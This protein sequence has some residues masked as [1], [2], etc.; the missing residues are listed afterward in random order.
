MY[1]PQTF[2]SVCK[3]R[4]KVI[5]GLNGMGMDMEEETLYTLCYVDN[6]VIATLDKKELDKRM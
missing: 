1:S 3:W 5:K 4:F 6:Q 2:V